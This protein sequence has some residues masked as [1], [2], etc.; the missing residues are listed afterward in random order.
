M[1]R[2]TTPRRK[3]YYLTAVVY[4]AA[5]SADSAGLYYLDGFQRVLAGGNRQSLSVTLT[6]VDAAAGPT[7]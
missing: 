1:K 4:P 5:T 2:G 3:S 6:P 7:N